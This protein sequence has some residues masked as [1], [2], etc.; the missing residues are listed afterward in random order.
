MLTRVLLHVI[1][2]ARPVDLASHAITGGQRPADDVND[3]GILVDRLDDLDRAKTTDIKGLTA[4]CRIERRA[5]E[6]DDRA[7]LSLGGARDSR[8]ERSARR[9]GV[10]NA[11]G[12]R[13]KA[14]S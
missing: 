13:R 14:G 7:A 10:V 2:A 8:L 6:H 5:I 12:H 11:I 3:L 4:G 9:L 1:E